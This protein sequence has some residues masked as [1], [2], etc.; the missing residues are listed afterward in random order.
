V[1]RQIYQ[2]AA[3][4]VLGEKACVSP[5]TRSTSS[6]AVRKHNREFRFSIRIWFNDLKR[7]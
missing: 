7:S 6:A 3:K 4:P 2:D 5:E 1:A